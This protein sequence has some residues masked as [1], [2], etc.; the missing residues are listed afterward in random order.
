MSS[1]PLRA[2]LPCVLCS[3]ASVLCGAGK[4]EVRRSLSVGSPVEMRSLMGGSLSRRYRSSATFPLGP[5][6]SSSRLF[7]LWKK[8]SCVKKQK[9][10]WTFHKNVQRNVGWSSGKSFLCSYSK[11][12]SHNVY[13]R[14]KQAAPMHFQCQRQWF[15]LWL[16]PRY[17]LLWRHNTKDRSKFNRI[18]VKKYYPLSLQSYNS[19]TIRGL[20]LKSPEVF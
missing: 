12:L 10:R 17:V 19:C 8:P 7:C 13:I 16:S 5:C 2:V 15:R 20:Q 6:S 18:S 1:E 14:W 11:H 3:C 9:Q 4:G